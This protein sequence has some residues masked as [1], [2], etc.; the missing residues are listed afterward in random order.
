MLGE[1]CGG[2]FKYTHGIKDCSNCIIPHMKDNGF[3]FIQQNMLIVIDKVK[4]E[5]IKKH[6]EVESINIK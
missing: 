5:Y 6:P 1:E 4:E 3:D 2:N